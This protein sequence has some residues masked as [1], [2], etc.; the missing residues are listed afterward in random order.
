MIASRSEVPVV[1]CSDPAHGRRILSE[2][3]TITN[4]FAVPP[5]L[6]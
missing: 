1:S 5:L 3:K 4:L 6:S 2:L